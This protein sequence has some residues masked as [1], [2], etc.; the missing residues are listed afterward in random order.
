MEVKLNNIQA[1]N[2]RQPTQLEPKR[3]NYIPTA[4]T[5]ATEKE[6]SQPYF[7]EAAADNIG[8]AIAPNQSPQTLRSPLDRR[9]I[10]LSENLKLLEVQVESA[11]SYLQ[12]KQ[13]ALDDFPN[14]H[15]RRGTVCAICHTSRHNREKCNKSPCHNVDLC[16]L[17]DKHPELLNDIRTLQRD[18]KELEQKY[19]KAKSE[20]DVFSAEK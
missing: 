19:A 17:K 4:S 15:E 5:A 10:E 16:K 14:A 18:L 12:G 13:K 3:L 9:A 2:H 11:K 7:P 8:L 20:C 6:T 1:E